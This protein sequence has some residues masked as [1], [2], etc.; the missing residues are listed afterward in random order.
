MHLDAVSGW[1]YTTDQRT[2]QGEASGDANELVKCVVL[3]GFIDNR[4][5]KRSQAVDRTRRQRLRSGNLKATGLA[6]YAENVKGR[7]SDPF[8]E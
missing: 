6:S 4:Y 3:G 7:T 5:F 8:S 1:S 2:S